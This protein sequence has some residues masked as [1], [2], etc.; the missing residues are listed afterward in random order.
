MQSIIRI[1]T[2]Y[3]DQLLRS[4]FYP[5]ASTKAAFINEYLMMKK[6]GLPTKWDP[7]SLLYN[8]I[9]SPGKNIWRII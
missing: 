3:N 5:A 9:W 1:E 2:T 4:T 7:N 6:I 8:K